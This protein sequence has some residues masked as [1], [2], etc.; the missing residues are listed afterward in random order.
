MGNLAIE[1]FD[2]NHQYSKS[3]DFESELAHYFQSL[4]P[5]FRYFSLL[6][7]L[8][9][10]EIAKLFSRSPRYHAVFSSCN[11]NYKLNN[12]AAKT[13]RW[14]L[15]CPKCRFVFL[16]LAPFLPK[17]E[18]LAIFGGNLL[19]DPAQQSGFAALVGRG[20]HKPFECVGEIEESQAAFFL[21]TQNPVWQQEI[22]VQ[23]F[24]QDI[25]PTIPHPESLVEQAFRFS[26]IHLIPP[27]F[28]E[29]LYAYRRS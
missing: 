4:L 10:L 9:E 24:K 7:P 14:C 29:K 12:T 8:S 21:L 2:V 5:G 22:I 17:T 28:L 15:N 26:P 19:A 6:R 23:W 20:T 18:L 11:G 27:E 16:A 25:L 3:F 13:A 1:G